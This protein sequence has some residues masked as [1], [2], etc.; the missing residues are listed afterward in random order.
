MPLLWL[1]DWR[2]LSK[3]VDMC[4]R[5]ECAYCEEEIYGRPIYNKQLEDY[6]CQECQKLLSK[7]QGGK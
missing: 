7:Q 1:G 2:S 4:D 5:K 3:G 6:V